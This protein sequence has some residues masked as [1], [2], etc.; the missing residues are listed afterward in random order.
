MTDE[1]NS[2]GI[3]AGSQEEKT[4]EGLELILHYLEEQF[5][6]QLLHIKG[7][8]SR[9]A[10]RLGVLGIYLA[11]MIPAVT[12]FVYWFPPK[13]T[14]LSFGV[15]IGFFSVFVVL[16]FIALYLVLK[17]LRV[18]AYKP[19]VAHDV[20]ERLAKRNEIDVTEVLRSF[21]QN[22]R[23]VHREN[24]KV[25]QERSQHAVKIEHFQSIAFWTFVSFLFMCFIALVCFEFS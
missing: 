3:H 21:V 4:R 10:S 23:Q 1:D 25:L 19:P 11:F 12:G 22:Y 5:K 15:L 24:E 18:K 14:K 17:Q 6:L 20:I 7:V 13:E 2:A 8:D 9:V 16:F